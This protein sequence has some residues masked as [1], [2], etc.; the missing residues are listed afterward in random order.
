MLRKICVV[1][2]VLA[3]G[4][5]ASPE[6]C[7][8]RCRPTDPCWP[9]Q[10]EWQKLNNTLAG[11]LQAVR[12]VA[13]VCHDPSF[14][15]NACAAV[16]ASYNDST[17]RAA[18]PG[19]VQWINWE[20]RPSTRESCYVDTARTT[21]CGQGRI[22]LYSA[23][24]Q[25]AADIQAAVR[26]AGKHNLRLAIKNSGHCYLGRSTAPESLQI[27]THALNSI[28]FTDNFVPKG[29]KTAEGPAVTVGAGVLLKPLYDAV[30]KHNV[31]VIAGSSHTVGIAGGYLQGGGH[32]PLGTWKGMGADNVLEYTV[33]NAEVRRCHKRS[34]PCLGSPG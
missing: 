29:G 22:S 19:A 21:P 27:A 7:R 33:V 4:G 17:W 14:D 6:S 15:A 18:H 13:S 20:T 9:S 34:H 11:H 25:S 24:V 30:A 3:A 5:F 10:S 31:T 8:C 16:K 2:L 23:A 12:P 26:F 32:S 1:V 28:E